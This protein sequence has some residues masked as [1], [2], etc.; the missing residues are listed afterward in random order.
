[1]ASKKGEVALR[2]KKIF[3]LFLLLVLVIVFTGCSDGKLAST[4]INDN[5]SSLSSNQKAVYEHQ[6]QDLERQLNNSKTTIHNLQQ[7]ITTYQNDINNLKSEIKILE[8]K[9]SKSDALIFEQADKMF[10]DGEYEASRK[11]LMQ[12]KDN[13][14]SES[15]FSRIDDKLANIDAMEK[16]LTGVKEN[17]EILLDN[18]SIKIEEIFTANGLDQGKLYNK[19]YP[20]GK[21][22]VMK[23][24]IENRDK[25][26]RKPYTKNLFEIVEKDGTKY[27]LTKTFV[28][29]ISK[30][31]SGMLNIDNTDLAKKFLI[32]N[33]GIMLKPKLPRTGYVYFDVP[34]SLSN[35]FSIGIQP[36]YDR[37]K[38]LVIPVSML[39]L[40]N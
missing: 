39:H 37:N 14:I 5:L 21:F 7:R 17:G 32:S 6:I 20:E 18:Y 1:M 29:V 16:A 22:L 4:K 19:I 8:E 25:E 12:I 24:T 3:A 10:A 26:E 28:N 11:L 34:K 13:N 15:I 9:I 23:V 31:P 35:D 30:D 27:S 36:G 2:N 40:N 38:H 33:S